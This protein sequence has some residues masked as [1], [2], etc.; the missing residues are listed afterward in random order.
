MW[1]FF[2]VA[3]T[4]II[5]VLYGKVISSIYGEPNSAPGLQMLLLWLFRIT[6]VRWTLKEPHTGYDLLLKMLRITNTSWIQRQKTHW[7]RTAIRVS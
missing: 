7:L 3:L 6:K 5:S 1:R 2:F 4:W